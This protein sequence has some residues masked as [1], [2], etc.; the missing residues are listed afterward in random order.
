MPLV[1]ITLIEGRD[2]DL[3]GNL[4]RQV[5][6]TVRNALHAPEENIRIIVREVPPTHWAAGGRTIAERRAAETP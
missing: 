2:T 1:E 5:H 4:I 6:E 3:I